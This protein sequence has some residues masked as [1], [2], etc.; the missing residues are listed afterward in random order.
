ML[1]HGKIA[2]TEANGPGER[3][4]IWFQGC[5][6][7]C[8]GC[9]NPE[10]HT[11]EAPETDIGSIIDWLVSLQDIEGVTFSGGEPLQ[12][13]SDLLTLCRVLRRYRPELS[14]GIFTGY[15]LR[16][17]ERG[18]FEHRLGSRMLPS[19]PESFWETLKP[20]LDFAVCGRFNA[21]Q[22]STALPLCGSANQTLEL[23]SA[24]YTRESFSQQTIEVR[25]N[26]NGL[27]QITGFPGLNF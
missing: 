16:E 21:A 17:L 2:K 10:S 19:A 13:Y 24:R 22:T 26:E 9:Q 6:L 27:V 4:A 11:F 3:A 7:N 8:A 25:I 12:H 18:S 14:I 23:L 15:T 5:T 20:L 1:L